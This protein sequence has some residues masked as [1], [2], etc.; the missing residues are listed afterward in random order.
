[1]KISYDSSKKDNLNTKLLIC[2]N[3]S[4]NAISENKNNKLLSSY[5]EIVSIL[6]LNKNDLLYFIYKNRYNVNEILYDEEEYINIEIKE[7]NRNLANYFSLDLLIND[8]KEMVNYIYPIQLIDNINN[9]QKSIDKNIIYKKT[10][11]A[12][13]IIDL[14]NNLKN[15]EFYD[16]ENDEK[17]N[18]IENENKDII[19]N[20]INKIKESFN[21]L[22]IKYLEKENIDNIYIDIIKTLFQPK[23]FRN[24]DNIIQILDQLQ[25]ESI[26]IT[27]KMIKEF[28]QIF[29]INNIFIK[30]YMIRNSNDLVN[31]NKINFY[32]II[33][34]YIFKES[35]FIYQIPFL[36]Q[37]KK[38]INNLIN[39]KLE[40]LSF[41][42]VDEQIK[43]KIE[44]LL[45]RITD[46]EYYYNK[47]VN[48]YYKLPKLNPILEYYNNYLFESK[49]EDINLIENEIKKNKIN[50]IDKYLKDYDKAVKMNERFPIIN[51]I[52]DNKRENKLKLEKEFNEYIN[53]WENLENKLKEQKI[54]EINKNDI[55]ILSVFLKNPEN[56]KIF[57][58]IFSKPIYKKFKQLLDNK[59]YEKKS[60]NSK[61]TLEYSNELENNIQVI[62]EEKG[63]TNNNISPLLNNTNIKKIEEI[64]NQKEENIPKGE[65]HTIK[66]KFPIVDSNSPLIE[67]DSDIDENNKDEFINKNE[68]VNEDEEIYQNDEKNKMSSLFIQGNYQNKKYIIESDDSEDNSETNEDKN[69]E[70]INNNNSLLNNITKFVKKIGE[71]ENSAEIV[72][73]LN[74][75]KVISCGLTDIK[76][77]EKNLEFKTIQEYIKDLDWINNIEEKEFIKNIKHNIFISTQSNFHLINLNTQ[78]NEKKTIPEK[79]INFSLKID[80]SSLFICGLECI[81]QVNNA[82]CK[83]VQNGLN[84]KIG[85]NYKEGIKINK[86]LFAFTSNRII[87]GQEDKINFYHRNSEKICREIKNYSFI[88]SST[89]L[90]LITIDNS[91]K[92][93]ILL[94]ACKKYIKGQ[95]NGILLISNLDSIDSDN[96]KKNNIKF[97]NTKIFEVHCF[98][99]LLNIDNN[100]IL[101]DFNSE[102]TNYFLVGGFETKKKKGILKLYEIKKKE[103]KTFDIE[104]IYDFKIEKNKEFNSFKGPI[105]CIEQTKNNGDILISCWDG[106]V[107]LFSNPNLKLLQYSNNNIIL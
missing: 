84:Y 17:L 82:F 31:I 39:N 34:K 7:E 94:C 74:D 1:M 106:N 55:H 33:F 46:S 14:I 27:E 24:I 78:K 5:S 93:K 40:E 56:E 6:K 42:N 85:G 95:K 21:Y 91:D 71:H 19:S 32:Y 63:K 23:H 28:S 20:N 98:I 53:E 77:Y 104:E 9:Y 41:V 75:Q 30:E 36:F 64:K 83:I 3:S 16:D 38:I 88:L 10:I 97:Y 80:D 81:S 79:H 70:E 29:D 59:K 101:K 26:K 12:K 22:N 87:S 66:T 11:L 48:Y 4:I 18:I 68:A 25:L 100:M 86:R 50:N 57:I 107:F 99:Q 51:F 76:I 49:K 72:K 58:N 105:S 2:Y 47:Y 54:E 44:D 35:I 8:N 90:T 65:N 73:E 92:D 43:N 15:Y 103:N 67:S 102:K 13:I 96:Y 60:N 61:T 37:T 62:P 45:K 69:K 89:G 52:F